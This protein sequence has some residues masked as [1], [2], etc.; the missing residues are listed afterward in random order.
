M[1]HVSSVAYCMVNCMMNLG[2]IHNLSADAVA[3]AGIRE[4]NNYSGIPMLITLL[5]DPSTEICHAAAGTLQN[6]ARE[7]EARDMI[8]GVPEGLVR[9][10]DLLFCSDVKCQVNKY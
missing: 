3:I 9:L 7:R 6:L 2:T 4:C 8:F 5:H 10:I 1:L